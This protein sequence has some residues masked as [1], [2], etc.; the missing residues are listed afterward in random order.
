MR[1]IVFVN[2]SNHPSNT[3]GEKQRKAIQ[4]IVTFYNEGELDLETVDIQFP[5]VDPEWDWYTV[6]KLAHETLIQIEK[7]VRE[8]NGDKEAIHIVHIMGEMGFTYDIVEGLKEQGVWDYR[9]VPIHSTTKRVVVEEKG[10]KIS[11][12]EFVRFRKY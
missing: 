8:H 6:W 7:T 5:P 3:W 9:F 11:Q 2:I 4:D 10:K 12:F 1:K